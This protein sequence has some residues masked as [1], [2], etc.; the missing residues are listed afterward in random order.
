MKKQVVI[1]HGGH[2]SRT[3][4]EHLLYLK[5]MRLDLERLRGKKMGW[6]ANLNSELGKSFEIIL[7]RMPN[8]TNARYGEW[9]IIF[10]KIIPF[11]KNGVVL[12]GHSLGGIF[13]A[14]YLAENKFPKKIRATILV[15]TPYDSKDRKTGHTL[16]DFAL[17]KNLARF[18]RQGGQIF[19]HQSKDDQI[20]P[21]IDAEKYRKALP[22][23]KLILFKKKGHFGQEK[24]PELAKEIKRLFQ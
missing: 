12:V 14:K 1:I 18:E 8:Q 21:A 20:V 5:K 13:L 11:L 23:A 24:F 3:H 4:K 9:K 15:A 17:P 6:K 2:V 7:P 10:R 16:G 22:D 19:I